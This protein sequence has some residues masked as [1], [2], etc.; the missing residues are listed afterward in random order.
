[1]AI[2]DKLRELSKN[3]Y[4][5][6]HPEFIRVFRDIQPELWRE[7]NHNPVEFLRRLADQAVEDTY[8]DPRMSNRLTQAFHKLRNYLE[9]SEVWGAWHAGPLRAFPVAYFSAEFGLHESLPIYSGGLG[10]LAGDHLKAA[11]DLGIPMVAVGLAYT[12]GYFEQ[13]LDASGWQHERYFSLSEEALPVE[14][15]KN[16]YGQPVRIA[17]RTEPYEIWVGI[18]QVRVGRNLLLLL[19]TNVDGN[20]DE[21]KAL[22]SRLY[23]G[24]RRTRILQELVLGVGGMRALRELGVVPGVLH[25]N[26]G[27]SAFAILELA[28]T[29]M[30]R[31][32]QS[33]HNVRELVAGMTV[34]TTHTAVP[35]GHDV[36][37]PALVEQALG[38]LRQQLGLSQRDFLALGRSDPNNDA[39]HFSM[40]IL[41]FRMSRSR[42]AVSFLHARL[43]KAIWHHLWR[44]TPQYQVPV[45]YITN[46]VHMDTWLSEPMADLYTQHLGPDWRE[47]MDDPRTWD[48][49]GSVDDIELW[50][51]NQQRRAHL[52][53]YVDRCVQRQERAR[54]E[55]IPCAEDVGPPNAKEGIGDPVPP[56]DRGQELA[57]AQAGDARD[58]ASEYVQRA[59]LDPNALTI[60]IARRFAV[61]KRMDLLFRDPTRLDRLVN[62]PQRKVQFIFA[63][64]A[65]PQDERGKYLIQTVFRFTRDP[66]F[67]GKVVFIEN[68]DINVARHLVQGVDA[69][70]NTPRRPLEA[71]GTSGQKVA[72]NGGLNISTL[73]GWWAQAYD[74][75]NGFAIGRGGEHS[76]LDFQDQVDI[77]ALYS[78]LENEVVPL[79]YDR[80]AD[81]IPRGWIARQKHA[82]RTLPWRFSARRMVVDYTLGC[83][84][85]AVGG[86]TS[87]LRVDVR[88]LSDVLGQARAG[89]LA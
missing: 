87:S 56:S 59:K 64:K 61:Y 60:G 62:N 35:A 55:S 76:H 21:D 10:V 11:S 20:S 17:V 58:T 69:W 4:W 71:S 51:K 23:G 36:F 44:G 2:A 22:T 33:F 24:D 34:F 32:G 77:Q 68:Y 70:L 30:E 48:A 81:G 46:G 8:R 52:V 7:V 85:R 6:W 82:L 86:L 72:V 66:R 65:H 45:N 37:E 14:L 63:G 27:H 54:L 43:T 19:D 84:L 79:F 5:A 38:P 80:D 88:L 67:V 49:I 3:L 39:E 25:L 73:D 78:V 31:D 9:A 13:S 12:Y 89:R 41:G 74:G 42:N 40:T 83:Y 57:P 53:E 26:E 1:M 47:R 28:R 75:D 29:L 50:E 16:E 15:V 18:W